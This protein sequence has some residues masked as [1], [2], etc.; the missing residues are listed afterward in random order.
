M[1]LF[2]RAVVRVLPAVPRSIVRRVASPY[3]AGSTLDDA[4]RVVASLNAEGMRAT[5][6]VLGE[7]IAR[8]DEAEAIARAYRDALAAIAEDG[9]DANISIKLT[10][11]GLK[12]DEG[13][14]RELVF[15]LVA[16]AGSAA[17]SCGS[18]WR[19]RAPPTRRSSSTGRSARTGTT[20]SGSSCRRRCGGRS[21]TSRRSP[22]SS[23]ACASAR[24]STSSRRRSPSRASTRCGRASSPA[25]TRCSRAR[26]ASRS[27]RT[28]SGSSSGPSSASTGS[29][30][31]AT[32][33]RCSSA[34][35]AERARQLVAGGHPLRIYVPYGEQ[36][37]E[38]SL[39]R[40]QENP[41]VAGY[42]AK[43][44]LGR[45]CQG[46]AS[47]SR[48]R[49]RPLQG[50]APPKAGICRDRDP[51]LRIRLRGELR[52]R[53]HD[54][55]RDPGQRGADPLRHG[56]RLGVGV[57][58]RDAALERERD[59]HD[60]PV[61]RVERPEL[62]RP[63]AGDRDDGA[64]DLAR[65]RG[66]RSARVTAPRAARGGSAPREPRARPGG[67]RPRRPPRSAC[68]CASG[69]SPGSFRWSDTS[70]PSTVSISVRLWSSRT[71]ATVMRRR[72]DALADL[73]LRRRRLD[74]DDDV[75]VR[76][77][78]AAPRPRR[79]RRAAWPCP[80]AA[81]GET[82]ITTSAKVRPAGLAEAQPANGDRRVEARD[83]VV[84]RLPRRLPA[85]G[86]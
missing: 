44:V 82:P 16:D 4:R 36:W 28:T 10:G 9:L 66:A 70:T 51:L 15:G 13:L 75:A 38:Y 40:L 73:R 50:S 56:R 41:K 47:Q 46:V 57:R 71:W 34:S 29:S 37:Y 21:P 27:R 20:A 78:R 54:D 72:P 19:T 49:S 60:E 14:C 23:R 1:R 58:E 5:V 68:A 25:S 12:L 3:I 8:P 18:T 61:V 55:V 84:R 83:R 39:R 53:V 31:G 76:E 69:R 42:V 62:A 67:W 85:R 59:E 74:V 2:D 22:R 26:A 81:P 63:A 45:L 32:S 24:G 30:P 80:T 79:D 86:P 35:A 7:E 17:R 33:C 77:A 43:D 6:D 65:R 48:P 11:F 64:L 52:L